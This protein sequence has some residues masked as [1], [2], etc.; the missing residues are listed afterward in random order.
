VD[1][2]RIACGLYRFPL[3]RTR[4]SLRKWLIPELGQEMH[5]ISLGHLE[6]LRK[7]GTS[8]PFEGPQ[9]LRQ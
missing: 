9:M 4:D 1:T 5:M 2:Q 3:R 8:K 6:R 7:S